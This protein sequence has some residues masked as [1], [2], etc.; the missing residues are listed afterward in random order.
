[1]RIFTRCPSLLGSSMHQI[2]SVTLPYF[3]PLNRI[4]SPTLGKCSMRQLITFLLSKY[5]CTLYISNPVIFARCSRAAANPAF[6]S[7]SLKRAGELYVVRHQCCVLVRFSKNT[8]PHLHGAGGR[9]GASN[10]CMSL[11]LLHSHASL[12]IRGAFGVSITLGS[13]IWSIMSC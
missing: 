10:S 2:T 11:H 6:N 9:T 7:D 5:P 1:M 13:P 8:L 12:I 4:V 3:S